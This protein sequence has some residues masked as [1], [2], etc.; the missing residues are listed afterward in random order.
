MSSKQAQSINSI[1]SNS[2]G[3]LP[4]VGVEKKR[5]ASNNPTLDRLQRIYEANF[6]NS[7]KSTSLLLS[8][9]ESKFE[10]VFKLKDGPLL[11]VSINKNL[12]NPTYPAYPLLSGTTIQITNSELTTIE[13]TL[14]GFYVTK[15]IKENK[16]LASDKD[17]RAL[18]SNELDN[19]SIKMGS[20]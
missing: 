13:S 5:G 6:S 9:T 4:P 8:D 18:L 16:W 17:I 1:S 2:G 19:L 11:L 14:T 10:K 7:H 20:H 15:F 3:S 12:K